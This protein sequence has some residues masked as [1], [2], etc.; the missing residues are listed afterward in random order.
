M[1]K[2][3]LD[4]AKALGFVPFEINAG[5]RPVGKRTLI[6]FKPDNEAINS[7]AFKQHVEIVLPEWEKKMA[8]ADLLKKDKELAKKKLEEE[9]KA[10]LNHVQ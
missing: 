10:R 3:T 9:N 5:P 1:D 6:P 2:A 8:E 4:Q 7:A